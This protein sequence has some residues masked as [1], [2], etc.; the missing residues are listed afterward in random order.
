[1][2]T[3]VGRLPVPY[4]YEPPD[5]RHEVRARPEKSPRS[6]ARATQLRRPQE[7]EVSGPEQREDVILASIVHSE[8][9]VPL[10]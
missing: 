7:C 4:R 6:P 5:A 9:A 3:A 8:T 2:Q 10:L 1:M